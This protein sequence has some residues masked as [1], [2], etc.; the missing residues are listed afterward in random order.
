MRITEGFQLAPIALDEP[1][2]QDSPLASLLRR[3]LPASAHAEIEADLRRISAGHGERKVMAARAD[4]P[5]LVQFDEWGRRVD[6]LITSEG[7]RQ[8]KGEFAREGVISIPFSRRHG[9]YSRLHWAAALTLLAPDSAMVA[10]PYAMTD[11]AT[12]VLELIGSEALKEEWLPQ[13][14][15]RDPSV[16]VQAGCVCAAVIVAEW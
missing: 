10:C 2:S 9:A 12:R 1:Y 11:G 16:A 8:L 5:R 4:E 14:T 13:L 3:L 7:W 15:S 6:K